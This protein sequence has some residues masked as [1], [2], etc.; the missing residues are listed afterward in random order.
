M[1]DKGDSNNG[2]N[3]EATASSRIY[4]AN[5]YDCNGVRYAKHQ[6]VSRFIYCK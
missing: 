2:P 5:H 6:G 3:G 1:S 4:W